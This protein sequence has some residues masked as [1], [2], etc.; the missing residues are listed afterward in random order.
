MAADPLEEVLE[1]LRRLEHLVAEGGR[2]TGGPAVRSARSIV[3]RLDDVWVAVTEGNE[4]LAAAVDEAAAAD[5][6]AAKATAADLA[7]LH[8]ALAA[9]R[10]AV[11]DLGERM[12]TGLGQMGRRLDALLGEGPRGRSPA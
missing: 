3:G 6:A 5:R 2:G 4:R 12:E 7:R 9:L 11:E 1:R 10:E 8:D